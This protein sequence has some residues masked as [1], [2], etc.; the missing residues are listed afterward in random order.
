V[1]TEAERLQGAADVVLLALATD[2]PDAVA[3]ASLAASEGHV[4]LLTESGSLAAATEAFLAERP[5]AEVWVLGG[6]AV[7]PED[8][9]DAAGADRRLAGP[10]RVDT[11]AAIAAALPDDVRGATLAQGYAEDGWVEGNAGAAVLQPLLITGPS[12]TDL[13]GAVTAAMAG[14]DGPL[15]VLG[16]PDRIADEAVAQAEAARAEAG[17]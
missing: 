16:G 5:E 13:P 15:T 17:R 12:T 1:A 10:T 6:D 4:I 2:W 9:A 8:V 3:G 14:R 11:A 7:I